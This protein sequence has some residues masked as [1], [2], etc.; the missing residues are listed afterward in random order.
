MI[1]FYPHVPVPF[2]I[3]T[4]LLSLVNKALTGLAFS[5]FF[6][7]CSSFNFPLVKFYLIQPHKSIQRINTTTF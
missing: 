7:V 5:F 1:L 2:P 4:L 3:F 6:Y